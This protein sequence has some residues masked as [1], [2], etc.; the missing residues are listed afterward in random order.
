MPACRTKVTLSSSA[1]KTY[2]SRRRQLFLVS[3]ALFQKPSR[4][5]L[6]PAQGYRGA[7]HHVRYNIRRASALSDTLAACRTCHEYPTG[8]FV[9]NLPM[10]IR[11]SKGRGMDLSHINGLS[12]RIILPLSSFLSF[13]HGV[14]PFQI[15]SYTRKRP[16][17]L[18]GFKTPK[19]E[20]A[21][22]H[23]RFDNSEYRLHGALPY[24]IDCLP[25]NRFEPVLHFGIVG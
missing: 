2:G 14:Q 9:K 15:P 10:R 5:I 13:L 1:V 24:G 4:H 12:F 6:S 25:R 20:T 8:F 19:D 22:S 17:A 3:L 7:D 23:D 21:K 16:F 11:P 18:Y